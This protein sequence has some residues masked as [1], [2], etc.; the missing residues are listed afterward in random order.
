[1]KK[2]IGLVIIV[3]LTFTVLVY[4]QMGECKKH[5]III[6]QLKLTGDQEKDIQKIILEMKKQMI[7]QKAKMQ[8]SQLDLEETLKAETPDKS[9]IEDKIKEM[10]DLRVRMHLMKVD[11][12]FDVNK[13]LTP[14][15]QKIW[16]QALETCQAME[17]QMMDRDSKKPMM[18]KGVKEQMQKK[19]KVKIQKKAETQKVD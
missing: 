18:K 13:L 6:K 11:S 7:D 17:C 16:R 3:L 8:K 15:Q 4:G 10:S 1:M 19:S 2:I 9:A 5:D 12:W 14:E